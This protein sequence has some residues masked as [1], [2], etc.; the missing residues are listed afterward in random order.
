MRTAEIMEILLDWNF[1]KK[2]IDT[3]IKRSVLINKVER[4][5]G[6][7]EITVVSGVRR[8]GKSTLLLQFLKSLF[9][10]GVRKEDT[11]IVNFEDPRF[12]NLNLELLNKIYETY[13]TEMNPKKEHYVVLDEI[14][15]VE[16]WEKFA[17]F[18]HESK[19]A[20][21]F[22]TGSSSKLLSSEY[23]TVLAGRHVDM[24]V[25]PLSFREFLSFKGVVLKDR[26]DIISKRHEIKRLMTEYL[27]WGGFPKPTLLEKEQ[28]KK[29][30]LNSYFRDIT[31]KDIAMRHKIKDIGKLEELAKYYLSNI[32]ALQSFNKIRNMLD[33]SIDTVERFSRYLSDAYM[34][35]FVKKFS[36]S[37]KEQILNP[38]KVY[39]I[40]TGLRNAISFIFMD[41]QG[42]LMENVVF[43]ELKKQKKEIFYW[44]GNAEVDFLVKDGEKIKQLIQVCYYDIENESARKREVDALLEAMK[45]LKMKEGI[46]ITYDYEGEEEVDKKKIIYKPLWKWLLEV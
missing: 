38:K 15:V 16:D 25:Y 26:T 36:F 43:L 30:L 5:S 14:Q 40:D 35:F 17:R 31:I 37:E 7:N 1:W 34:I 22:L 2:E 24:E 23:A 42:R 18:L 6:M 4:L 28:D 12:K 41:N 21:V 13:L 32:S 29:E 20:Q 45:E 39:C 10:Q 3:G 19:K 11:L 46:I 9:A 27:K 8:S 44:K 33:I